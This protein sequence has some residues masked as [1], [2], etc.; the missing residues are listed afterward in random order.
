MKLPED[1]LAVSGKIRSNKTSNSDFYSLNSSSQD[2]AAEVED[3]DSANEAAEAE[4]SLPIKNPT[5]LVP[6]LVTGGL[7][8]ETDFKHAT[9]LGVVNFNE[10]LEL[11][12]LISTLDLTSQLVINIY[13][14]TLCQDNLILVGGTSIPLFDQETGCLISGDVECMV[15]PKIQGCPGITPY[16]GEILTDSENLVYKNFNSKFLRQDIDRLLEV[17]KTKDLINQGIVPK[18]PWLDQMVTSQVEKLINSYRSN[19]FL[20]LTLTFPTYKQKSKHI[21]IVYSRPPE[22]P[23]SIFTNIYEETYRKIAN[24]GSYNENLKPTNEDKNK[25]DKIINQPVGMKLKPH[26]INLI[27]KYKDYLAKY[28][29]DAIVRYCECVRWEENKEKNDAIRLLNTWLKP[30]ILVCL[31]LLDIQNEVVRKYTVQQLRNFKD[32]VLKSLLH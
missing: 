23:L 5:N 16:N 31:R 19:D 25:L 10:N 13:Q 6:D 2:L 15:W 9:K 24:S 28:S 8:A 11:P 18:I 3:V 21:H 14:T 17:K 4:D 7:T 22:K 26:E 32:L 1:K 20:Y 12:S 29:S 27:L 30:D